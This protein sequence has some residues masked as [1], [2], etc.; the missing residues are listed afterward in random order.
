[1]EH[2]ILISLRSF[3][4][5]ETRVGGEPRL[6]RP[7]RYVVRC[8]VLEEARWVFAF[9]GLR[10]PATHPSREA[11][12]PSLPSCPS[13]VFV[14]CWGDGERGSCAWRLARRPVRGAPSPEPSVG[15]LL[16]QIDRFVPSR[17]T[18]AWRGAGFSPSERLS[19][20]RIRGSRS[21]GSPPPT[22][23]EEPYEAV[24]PSELAPS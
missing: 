3:G 2:A 15:G 11:G 10:S 13:R 1:M 7:Y 12:G 18:K 16:L 6:P 23:P 4:S 19:G 24:A 5:V 14:A 9:V 21:L 8:C 17:A 20:P 22:R